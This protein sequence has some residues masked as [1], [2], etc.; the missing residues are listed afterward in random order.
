MSVPNER[1]LADRR[2]TEW[3]RREQA[4]REHEL[5]ELEPLV[6]PVITISRQFGAGAVTVAERLAEILGKP[7]EVWEKTLIEAVATSAKVRTEMVETLDE[8]AQS[9]MDEMLRRVFGREVMETATYRKHLAQTLLALAQQGNKIIVGRGANFVLDHAL[10][11]RLQASEQHRIKTTMAREGLDREAATKRLRSM[12]RSR[13]EF[14]MSVFGRDVNDP[15]AYDMVLNIETLGLEPSIQA[16][17]AAARSLYGLP[18]T[19]VM[20]G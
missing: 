6:Q 16:I 8:R 13:A 10:N 19:A 15:T 7:W 14:T 17:I 20:A 9:W 12:D 11:V 1:Q 4:T 18:E 2:V 3:F 5:P